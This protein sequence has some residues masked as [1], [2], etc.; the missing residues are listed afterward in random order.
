M[1][2][3]IFKKCPWK[4]CISPKWKKC[5]LEHQQWV[6]PGLL[7]QKGQHPD[8]GVG[9]EVTGTELGKVYGMWLG[10]EMGQGP[11]KDSGYS[12]LPHRFFLEIL[13]L[14]SMQ[15]GED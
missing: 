12:Y 15:F 4:A 10:G 2:L 13:F 1:S 14:Q 8:P 3:C 5:S 9:E 6:G 7:G 11:I